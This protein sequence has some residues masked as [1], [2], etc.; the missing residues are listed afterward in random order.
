[1][2]SRARLRLST[3]ESVPLTTSTPRFLS[4][5]AFGESTLRVKARTAGAFGMA[6]R[7]RKT[8]LPCWP[9]AP[10]MRMGP[11]ADMIA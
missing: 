1:M 9:V 7:A 2:P 4:S 3:S 6:W 8:A 11:M 5:C 10:T